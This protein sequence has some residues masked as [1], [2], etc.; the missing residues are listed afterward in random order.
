MPEPQNRYRIFLEIGKKRVFAGALDWPGWCRQ[1]RDEAAAI[2]ALLDAGPRY[3]RIIDAA[4]L[5]FEAPQESAAFDIVERVEGNSTTDFGAPNMALASDE[6]AIGDDELRRLQRLLKAYWVAFDETVEKAEGKALRKGPRGGG[7]E[8]DGIV[9]HIVESGRSYLRTLG[10]K[11]TWQDD[12]DN[13]VKMK[14][15]REGVLEGLKEG[16]AGRLPTEGP[17]GG[18]R[19]SPRQFVR[20]LA[21]HELDHVWEIED[22]IVDGSDLDAD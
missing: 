12:E 2:Q 5:G 4:D 16:A 22:R 21:W 11:V 20:R 14:R 7:R 8:L 18:K 3:A 19:W 10:W 1:G 6:E 17:R 9:N 13:S 15:L